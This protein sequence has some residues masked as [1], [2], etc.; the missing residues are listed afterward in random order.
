MSMAR[1][2][3]YAPK[4]TDVSLGYSE[5]KRRDEGRVPSSI[6]VSPRSLSQGQRDFVFNS[7][8]QAGSDVP[9]QLLDRQPHHGSKPVATAFVG[10]T[11]LRAAVAN[12]LVPPPFK[13]AAVLGLGALALGDGVKRYLPANALVEVSPLLG[14][15]PDSRGG[16][17]VYPEEQSRESHR[18]PAQHGIDP[19]LNE[20]PEGRARLI[21]NDGSDRPSGYSRAP[22]EHEKPEGRAAL[23]PPQKGEYVLLSQ[24]SKPGA[25]RPHEVWQ[26]LHSAPEVTQ[27]QRVKDM[28]FYPHPGASDS[29]VDHL[30]YRPRISMGSES[31]DVFNALNVDR[32]RYGIEGL[33]EQQDFFEANKSANILHLDVALDTNHHLLTPIFGGGTQLV[34]AAVESIKDRHGSYPKMIRLTLPEWQSGTMDRQFDEIFRN[35]N[36]ASLQMWIEKGFTQQDFESPGFQGVMNEIQSHPVVALLSKRGYEVSRVWPNNEMA[37][38]NS[39]VLSNPELIKAQQGRGRND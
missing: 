28:S 22:A 2:S 20:A 1:I 17:L 38:G 33:Y 30:H 24:E 4:V 11:L 27:E 34:E 26:A 15:P 21:W 18:L 6:G 5:V 9:V 8:A 37:M 12:L 19:K 16:V 36:D 7:V 39:V 29:V 31:V 13:A 10:A 3:G 14:P 23:N 32:F 25:H 35:S